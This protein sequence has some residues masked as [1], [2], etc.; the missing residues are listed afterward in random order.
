[1]AI[2]FQPGKPENGRALAVAGVGEALRAARPHR[3]FTCS[4][5]DA[6]ANVVTRAAFAAW[7]YLV[8]LGEDCLA[9]A[10]VQRRSENQAA[11]LSSVVY[12]GD[13]DFVAQLAELD[14]LAAEAEIEQGD[15][16]L[17]FLRVRGLGVAA[18]W[19]SS[20]T[21]GV[22]DLFVP[23]PPSQQALRPHEHTLYR[24]A[25]QFSSAVRELAN[26]K[27]KLVTEKDLLEGFPSH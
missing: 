4:L 6:E 7:R 23:V 13:G 2:N 10:K 21:A 8:F 3:S 17:R 24:G 1:M 26:K 18:W 27:L 25:E 12:G 16:E 5:A 14:W 15:F 22:N 11:I 9:A 19:L 20:V